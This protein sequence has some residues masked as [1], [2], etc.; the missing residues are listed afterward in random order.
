MNPL[1][2]NLGKLLKTEMT[3]K[4][5]Q[6]QLQQL[7]QIKN[8][9][10]A[11]QLKD[12]TDAEIDIEI[13][14]SINK[15][16]LSAWTTELKAEKR[17]RELVAG[18]DVIW[19]PV[20]LTARLV[21][22]RAPWWAHPPSPTAPTQSPPEPST[23]KK[24]PMTIPIHGPSTPI[25]TPE[26]P[27]HT[28]SDNYALTMREDITDREFHVAWKANGS[29]FRPW[30]A[31][32]IWNALF[33][34]IAGSTE[35]AI[36][37]DKL[38]AMESRFRDLTNTV[39]E[40]QQ[41]PRPGFAPGFDQSSLATIKRIIEERVAGLTPIEASALDALGALT[42]ASTSVGENLQSFEKDSLNLLK[43]IRETRQAVDREV[44]QIRHSVNG[45][46]ALMAEDS[47]QSARLKE[48]IELAQ[49]LES[50]RASGTFDLLARLK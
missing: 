35:A 50:L 24:Q 33:L 48:F 19:K 22:S 47:F 45:L 38:P 11:T 28:A 36:V 14:Q 31:D 23:K 17:R 44:A 18:G 9:E 26:S 12:V 40:R 29:R 20:D 32:A 7:I 21:V 49:K 6:A 34:E 16:E 42:K 1:Y 46:K 43:A 10:V 5:R 30:N 2:T 39:F 27:Q 41:N 13:G 8:A 25:T 15:P 3:M 4:R 37:D